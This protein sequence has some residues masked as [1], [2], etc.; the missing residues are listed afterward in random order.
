MNDVMDCMHLLFVQCDIS[1]NEN[2]GTDNEWLRNC[3]ELSILLYRERK[4]TV[5]GKWNS[6]D[7]V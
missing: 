2:H 6:Y 4:N 7:V 1:S 3:F 5:A